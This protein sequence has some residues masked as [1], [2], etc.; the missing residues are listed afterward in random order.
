[1]K[2][3]FITAFLLICCAFSAKADYLN[4]VIQDIDGGE[5]LVPLVFLNNL[6][7]DEN[8]MKV[9]YLG[10]SLKVFEYGNIQK[11]NFRTTTSGVKDLESEVQ[12]SLFPNPASNYVSVS[13][14]SEYPLNASVYGISGSKVLTVMLYS[15]DDRIDISS[16]Q[17]GTFFIKLNNKILKFEKYEN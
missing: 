5:K 2:K 1:M 17:T 4:L 6:T 15:P 8:S 14:I 16:L 11:I 12:Y 3:L 9:N 10:D 13:G 7:F